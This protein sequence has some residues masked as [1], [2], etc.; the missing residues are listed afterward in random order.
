MPHL[1]PAF[2]LALLIALIQAGVVIDRWRWKQRQAQQDMAQAITGPLPIQAQLDELK[3]TVDRASSRSSDSASAVTEKVGSL[4]L[5][6]ARLSAEVHQCRID[7]DR[8]ETIAR[9][10][11]RRLD[12]FVRQM[13]P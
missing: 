5:E 10:L 2:W 3:R 4:E 9:D 8:A 1:D 13:R 11:A 12:D 7:H 6:M